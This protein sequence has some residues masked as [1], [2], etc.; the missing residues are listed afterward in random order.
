M[1]L[2]PDAGLLYIKIPG[3]T[4]HMDVTVVCRP[5]LSERM[6]IVSLSKWD[7]PNVLTVVLASLCTLWADRLQPL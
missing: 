5:L 3:P 6:L 2:R 7:S 1:V 4:V